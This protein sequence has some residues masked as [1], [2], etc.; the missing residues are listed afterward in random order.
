MEKLPDGSFFIDA[1]VDVYRI[2][3][4]YMRRPTVYPL[5]W[6]REK[7]FD[8]AMYSR[9]MAEADFFMLVDLRDWIMKREY[10]GAVIVTHKTEIK[11]A[12]EGAWEYPRYDITDGSPITEEQDGHVNTIGAE[13]VE[14]VKFFSIDVPGDGAFECPNNVPY[15][16]SATDCTSG[17]ESSC[18]DLD[19]LRGS[20]FI[21]PTEKVPCTL[22]CVWKITK[23]DMSVCYKT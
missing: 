5:L 9:V 1:D 16:T 21:L 13:N 7:G 6:T 19:R 23:L 22:V 15:H 10:M 18:I 2:I 3:L 20:S 14:L 8:H 12:W 11:A 4:N 17:Y